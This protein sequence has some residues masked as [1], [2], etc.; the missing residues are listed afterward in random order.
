MKNI[1]KAPSWAVRKVAYAVVAL[2]VGILGAVGILSEVDAD[3]WATSLDQIIP[4]VLGVIAP[5][6]AASKTHAGSD[7]TVTAADLPSVPDI[8]AAVAEHLQGEP[9]RHAVPEAPAAPVGGSVY[10]GGE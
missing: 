9:G 2:V 4:W 3:K 5:A 1:K 8:A 6:V 10:P 7:S